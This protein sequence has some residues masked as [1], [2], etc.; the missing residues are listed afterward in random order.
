MCKHYIFFSVV[1]QMLI[2]WTL[3]ILLSSLCCLLTSLHELSVAKWFVLHPQNRR[4]LQHT[5]RLIWTFQPFKLVIVQVFYYIYFVLPS[6]PQRPLKHR[7]RFDLLFRIQFSNSFFLFSQF[8]MN[9]AHLIK[10]L[11]KVVYIR[12]CESLPMCLVCPTILSLQPK[13]F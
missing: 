3:P 10:V 9:I 12:A 5:L 13:C 7:C 2:R 4:L 8:S 6:L 11:L 1:N